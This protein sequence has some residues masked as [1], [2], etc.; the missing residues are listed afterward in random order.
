MKKILLAFFIMLAMVSCRKDE[1]PAPNGN[2]TLIGFWTNPQYS[3]TLV[4]YSRAVNLIENEIGFTFQAQDKFIYRQNSG[5]CGTPPITTADYEGTWT[6]NDSIINITVG[7]WGGIAEYTWK[8]I[9]LDDQELVIAVVKS[10]FY[11]GK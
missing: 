7:Y 10:S 9:K 1:I 3:D 2:D 4:A 5:W 11:E 6:R 8:I